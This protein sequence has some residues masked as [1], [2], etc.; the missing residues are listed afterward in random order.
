MPKRGYSE[1]ASSSCVAQPTDKPFSIAFYNIGMPNTAF[2]G[3]REGYDNLGADLRKLQL[4]GCDAVCIL[5]AG[6]HNEG[7]S[8]GTMCADRVDV[9]FL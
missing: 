5:E 2:Q 6:N 7:Q 1:Q 4:D 9:P 8:S 3:S